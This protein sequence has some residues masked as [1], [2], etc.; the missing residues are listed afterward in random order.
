MAAGS[1]QA[2]LRTAKNAGSSVEGPRGQVNI[3]DVSLINI[4][5][6]IFIKLILSQRVTDYDAMAEEN[7]LEKYETVLLPVHS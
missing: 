6:S 4:L 5:P 2:S 3:K 7:D 1:N